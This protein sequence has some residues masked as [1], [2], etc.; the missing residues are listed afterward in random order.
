MRDR[1]SGSP[2]GRRL[3]SL[4]VALILG[5]SGCG[6]D[7][8]GVRDRLLDAMLE[9]EDARGSGPSGLGSIEEGLGSVD[10]HV[11]AVAVRAI[12]RFEDPAL[13]GLISPFLSSPDP[14]VRA[15]AVNALGQAV[16]SADGEDVARLLLDHLGQEAD[17]GVRGVFGRTLGRLGYA[18][19]AGVRMAEEALLEL[20]GNGNE[21][22]PFPTLLGAAMG[23][24]WLARRNRDFGFSEATVAR[25]R[26]LVSY[27]RQSDGRGPEA[28]PRVRRVALMALTAAGGGGEETLRGALSDPDPDVRR[29]ALAEVGRGPSFPGGLEAL[30]AALT[31]PIPRV[32][33]QAVVA[34]AAKAPED[35]RCA[36]LLEAALDDHPQV[37]IA[38]LDLLGQPCPD[39]S[40]QIGA[41]K[42]FVEEA[43]AAAPTRWHRGAHGLVALAE[44]SPGTASPLI[45][46]YA[47]HVSPFARAYA[48]Q[49]A[50]RTGDEE[51]L[52]ALLEDEDP[53]VR[54]A[55]VQGLF[56]LRGHEADGLLLA[57]LGQDDP[58]LL[59]T[60][61]GL[62]EGTPAPVAA[63]APLLEA[64]RR[65]SSEK[66]ETLRDPRM[67]IIERL[68]EVAQGEGVGDPPDTPRGEVAE[69]LEG[70]LS[71]YD[72][73]V[74][75]RVAELLTEWT[76]EAR[77]ATP[78]PLPRVPVP[79]RME[80]D[81]LARA[82]VVLEMEGGGEIEIR[83]F[84]DLAPTNAARFAD[85][86]RSGVLDGLTFHRVVPN[87]VLQGG[88][89]NAN[90]MS[91]HGAYT[92][93]EIGLQSN[94]RETVGTSTRGRDTGD[95]QLFINLVDNLRLDH[96]Y[97]IFGE[98]VAGMDVVDRV[99]EG[100]VIRRARVV[101]RQAP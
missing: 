51:V 63:V 71:D 13:I 53:N 28:A 68:A 83:L 27:G 61:A 20:T 38:A 78:R 80:L 2:Y 6:G 72:P 4:A 93:D 65:I 79:S 95:G 64:L 29:L 14:E 23:L 24:E 8:G 85:L 10:P 46:R 31:D 9:A 67:G 44:V 21:D 43:D 75:D 74:A 25:L 62:L 45:G 42:G 47:D 89:P 48:A 90:E 56:R 32:R 84:A 57:Q 36:G 94:W 18:D 60:V 50:A 3:P 73:V 86:A 91:G 33:T 26:A 19:P 77:G 41:L 17:P 69:A 92:R 87:F 58:Q 59:L 39:T 76:G 34:Y 55:A 54:T 97:S 22:A 35:Q 99:V 1:A 81:R 101:D 96:N 66:Q 88:S 37:A 82:L 52:E 11:Q 40:G 49:A 100:E 70:Y 16:F 7:G 98:V 30:E 5:L 15:E 12:G